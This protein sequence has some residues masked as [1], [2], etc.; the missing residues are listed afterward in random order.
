M[1]AVVKTDADFISMIEA[2]YQPEPDMNRWAGDFLSAIGGVVFAPLGLVLGVAAHE[3]DYSNAEIVFSVSSDPLVAKVMARFDMSNDD[4]SI[5]LRDTDIFRAAYYPALPVRSHSEIA[6]KL[7]A[8]KRALFSVLLEAYG[9]RDIL[10]V[11][12]FPQPGMPVVLSVPVAHLISLS[13]YERHL[14]LRISG[15]LDSAFRLRYRPD[16]AVAAVISPD[17]RFLGLDDTSIERPQRERLGERVLTLERTRL[18]DRRRDPDA[19]EDWQALIEG[20]YSVLLRD[21]TD[22]KRHYLLIRNGTVAEEHARFSAREIDVVRMAARGFTGKSITYTLGLPPSSVST[23]LATAA[24]KV[25]LRSRH[26]L[27]EVASAMFGV[28]SSD[29]HEATLTQAEREVLDLLRRGLSNA[30]IAR[31]RE[32]SSHTVA[33]QIAAILQKTGAP[34]RR[35]LASTRTQ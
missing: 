26:A 15:H 25:G 20:R 13:R 1:S 31:V 5:S 19:L 17:G 3:D 6:T 10:V 27:V 21:D 4:L 9:C 24:E 16:L 35:A 12:A 18:R 29:T 32:R 14:L 22:G 23:A 30:E 8:Q 28:R 34:S 2:L 33:N 7:T 11:F